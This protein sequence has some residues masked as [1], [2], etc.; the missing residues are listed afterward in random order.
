MLLHLSLIAL[1]AA[2]MY[3]IPTEI[4]TSALVKETLALL[5]THRTLLIGNETLRIPVP[6]HKHH[7]LCTEEI[8]QGIGTLESQTVQGGTVE[9]LF[10]N[11]S[12]IKKYIDGQKVSYTHSMET[13]FVW[14]CLFLWNWQFPIISI[15]IFL[16]SQKKCGEERRRV[17]QFL[18]YLQEFLGVMN[19]EWIIE[20]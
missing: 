2:Y 6:V 18:D 12:L 19:T 15:V 11:L 10:K 4:P 13:V 20:S 7:Q 16:F 9:R 8:F 5:S 17:N 14:L 3:A 1:G